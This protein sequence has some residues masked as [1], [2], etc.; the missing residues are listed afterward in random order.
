LELQEEIFLSVVTLHDVLQALLLAIRIL[1]YRDTTNK[2]ARRTWRLGESLVTRDQAESVIRSGRVQTGCRTTIEN[3][4]D[5]HPWITADFRSHP[6]IPVIFEA[7]VR[8]RYEIQLNTRSAGSDAGASVR[9]VIT[10]I[11]SRFRGTSGQF[12]CEMRS[13]A[14][15]LTARFILSLSLFSL[16]LFSTRQ[17]I[18]DRMIARCRSL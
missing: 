12:A 10:E 3:R 1:L 4:C 15:C 9:G 2:N 13:P 11:S 16:W 6:E 17:R 14:G 7:T 18:C 5:V 8:R